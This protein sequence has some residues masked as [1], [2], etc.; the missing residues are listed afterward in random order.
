MYVFNRVPQYSPSVESSCSIVPAVISMPL[1][2]SG[3]VLLLP[4][5]RNCL[6]NNFY[7]CFAAIAGSIILFHYGSILKQY[8]ECPVIL[9]TSEECGTGKVLFMLFILDNTLL[10]QD[11]YIEAGFVTFWCSC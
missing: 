2:R 5:A 11:D 4:A 10:R 1:E 3:L 7:S 9:L 6:K 8:D